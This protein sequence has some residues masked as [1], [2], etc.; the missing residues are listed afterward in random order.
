MEPQTFSSNRLIAPNHNL[1]S[2]NNNK[3]LKL[4]SNHNNSQLHNANMA[5]VLQSS[6]RHSNLHSNI[7]NLASNLSSNL[8]SPTT[9]YSSYSNT[10]NENNNATSESMGGPV[11]SLE[12]QREEE[13]RV[14]RQIANSN[15]RRRMQSINNGFISLRTIIP[16]G[17]DEKLSKAAVL[18]QTAQYSAF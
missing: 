15:E 10:R 2:I 5:N 4:D 8:N 7:S 3:K 11:L 14:R 6:V 12:K 17:H 9:S 16:D 13:R 1:T 18:M